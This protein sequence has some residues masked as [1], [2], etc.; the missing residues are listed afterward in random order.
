MS[1]WII[2]SN[3]LPFSYDKANNGLKT[4]S[5]GLVTAIRGIKTK[6]EV[7]WIGSIPN[8]VPK[9]LVRQYRDKDNIKFSFPDLDSELYDNY[10]NGFC[11]DV[12]WPILHYESDSVK[13]S[14]DRWQDYKKVN[15]IFAKHVAKVAK[16]DDIIWL[17]DYQLFLVPKLL[18]EIN[19]DLKVGFFLHVPFPSSEIWK[20]LPVREEILESVIHADLVGFHDFSYLRH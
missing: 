5:G 12:L 16:K 19:P 13:F 10:Y 15:Q 14:I 4:S 18:K 1:R 9:K 2:V 8:N 3:R 7:L 17:H 11:N 20:Q 6:K